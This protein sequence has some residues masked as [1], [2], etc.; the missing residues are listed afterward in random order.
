MQYFRRSIS[1]VMRKKKGY[2]SLFTNTLNIYIE[3]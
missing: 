1:Y 3:L 2:S